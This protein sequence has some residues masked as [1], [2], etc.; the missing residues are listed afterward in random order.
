MAKPHILLL[1]HGGWGMSLVAGA[2]MIMGTIDCVT[3][4]ALLP[5]MTFAEYCAKVDAFSQ[6]MPEGS[7]ILTD[8][9]GGTTSNVAAKIGRERGFTVLSG[10]NLPLLIEACSAIMNSGE[11][12]LDT[13][14]FAGKT[15]VKDVVEEIMISLK[16][17]ADAA[18][19]V[20]N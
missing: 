17:K 12:D 5:E 3:E 13:V 4:I 15:A 9:F 2:R 8:V 1:T 14:L 20:E 16:K 11:Y 19:G 7:L 10:L 6:D 18:K